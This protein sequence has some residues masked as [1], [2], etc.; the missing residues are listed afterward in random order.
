MTGDVWL[1]ELE[2]VI[3]GNLTNPCFSVDFLAKF[4]KTSRTTFYRRVR[5]KTGLSVN[6][7]VLSIRLK[8][9]REMLIQRKVDTLEELAFAVGFSD[10]DYLSRL[11]RQYFD[12]SPTAYWTIEE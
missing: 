10:A 7:Y 9:A 3:R 2:T 8:V 6:R 1:L 4:M 12:L 11:F 5:S